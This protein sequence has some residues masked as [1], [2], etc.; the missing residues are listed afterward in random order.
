VVLALLALGALAY[1]LLQSLV[2]P[3]LPVFATDLHTTP[4]NATWVLTVFLLSASVATPVLGRLGDMLG[5]H[6]VLVGVL[7]T[8]MIGTLICAL[9]TNLPVLILGRAV[10]GVGGALF[11]LSFAIVRDELPPE[12]VPAGIGLL[13]A[14]LGIGAGVGIVLA[15]PIVEHLSWH[16]LFWLPLVLILAAT[17]GAWRGIPESPVRTPGRINWAGAGLLSAALVALLLG[18]SE[19]HAWGWG[20]A[21]VLGLLIGSVLLFAAWVS[22]ELRAEHPLVDMRMMRLRGVW[23]TNLA[24]LLLGFGMFGSFVLIPQI[25]ELPKITGFGFGASV[26]MAGVYLLPSSALM[27]VFGSLAGVLDRR[28]GSKVL[29]VAGTLATLAAFAWLI[30]AHAQP[31]HLIVG[32]ALLGTGIGLAFAAMANLIVAAVPATQTGVATGINTIARSVGGT[33]G[34]QL[35]AALVAANVTAAGMPLESGFTVSFVV[36]T[37]GLALALLAALAIPGRRTP[38]GPALAPG[39]RAEGALPSR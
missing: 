8:L 21:R 29:M 27:L 6:R 25:V 4:S 3:A 37:G 28:V 33:V 20:S 12:K 1:A 13:S 15:G 16:W 23:T 30:F 39:D 22:V 31:W 34:A 38:A 7:A 35:F 26:T 9:A 10:S 36:A 18:V 2:A 32:T 11:P 5:K 24:A 17:I 14:I 19:G